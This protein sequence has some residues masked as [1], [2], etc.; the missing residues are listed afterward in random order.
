MLLWCSSYVTRLLITQLGDH[1]SEAKV[2]SGINI[3]HKV[4]MPRMIMSPSNTN[5]PFKLQGKQFPLV[6]CYAMIINK[7]QGQTLSNLRI[8]LPKTGF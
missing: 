1:I 4:L 3:G 8:Y 2:I 7:S 6:V 5:L